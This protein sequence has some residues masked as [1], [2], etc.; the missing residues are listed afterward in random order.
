[1]FLLYTNSS[2]YKNHLSKIKQ[3]QFYKVSLKG[4]RSSLKRIKKNKI[5]PVS[6]KKSILLLDKTISYIISIS[7]SFTNLR[8]YIKDI[9]G[10]VKLTFSAGLFEIPKKQKY[11]KP[12]TIIKLIH[13]LKTETVFVRNSNVAIHL[14]NFTKFLLFSTINSLKNHY[15]TR[16]IKV[17]NSYPYNGCRPKKIKRKKYKN[18]KF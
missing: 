17:F 9:K 1:M 8:I 5:L 14:H 6:I 11:I 7:F 4:L 10:N 3:L 2:V 18:L 15:N 12:I 13:L 16:F